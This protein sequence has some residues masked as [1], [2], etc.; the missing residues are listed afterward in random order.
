MNFVNVKHNSMNTEASGILQRLCTSMKDVAQATDLP[1][2]TSLS[3]ATT[4]FMVKVDPIQ[5]VTQKKDYN[6]LGVSEI[7]RAHKMKCNV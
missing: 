7:N 6:Y 2:Y 5:Y 3:L 4:Q 1:C